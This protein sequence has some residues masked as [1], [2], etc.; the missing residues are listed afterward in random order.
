MRTNPSFPVVAT[1]ATAIVAQSP[2]HVVVPAAYA[3]NDALAY[4]WI[5]GADAPLRQQILVGPTHLQGMLPMA[6][7]TALELRRTAANEIYQAGAMD[8]TVQ[9]STAPHGPL[10]CDHRWAQNIGAD[11]TTVFAGTVTLPTSPAT[12]TGTGTPV[13]WTPQNTL[14]IQFSQPFAYHG[15]TLCVELLGTPISGSQTW[16]MA[17]AAA[18]VISG[19]QL[20]SIGHGCGAHGGPQREWSHAAERTLIPSKRAEFWAY[21][22]NNALAVAV[23]GDAS[24]WPI[25]LTA[26]GLATPG[27]DCYLN[28]AAVICALPTFFVPQQNWPEARADIEVHLPAHPMC[29]G[30]RLSTQWFDLS[31][32]ATSNAFTWTVAPAIPTLDMALLECHP[33]EATGTVTTDLAPVLRFETQ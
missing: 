11:V 9:L 15:G 3:Q 23:I 25:P 4:E 20:T 13:A 7:I 17:D 1:L 27:C 6:A 29:F 8:L 2:N 32:Q 24:P 12:P 16:W 33:S 21:G 26:F 5:A 22:P 19:Y 31:Q 30:L 28:P 10:D 14:R 18:D